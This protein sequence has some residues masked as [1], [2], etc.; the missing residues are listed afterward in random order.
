MQ[1][2]M[3]GDFL[4]AVKFTAEKLKDA[5]KNVY[6]V[7]HNDADGICS[8]LIL[9]IAL[10]RKGRE[11]ERYCIEKVHPRIIEKIHEGK[12]NDVI[13]YTDLGG[14]ALDTIAK[15]DGERN[16]IFLIDHHPA[17][18]VESRKVIELDS[19]L[20]GISGDLF[21]SASS[22]AYMVARGIDEKNKDLAYLAVIGS[23]GDYHDRYGGVL[24]IDRLSLEEAVRLGQA[25]IKIEKMRE[26]YYIVPLKNYAS[27]VAKAFTNLGVVGYLE[28]GYNIAIDC[29]LSG[30]IDDAI[31]KGLEYEKLKER[32]FKEMIEKLKNGEL[33]KERYV[34]WFHAKDE[35]YPMGVKAIGE[36]CQVTKD[37]SFFDDDKYIIGFQNFYDY[38]P[39]LGEIKL[40][41]VKVSGRTPIP[42]ERKIINGIMPGFD[43]LIPEAS[44]AVNGFPDATHKVAAATLIE[45]GKEEEFIRAFERIIETSQCG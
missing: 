35:F 37:M 19:E 39:D 26:R 22:L 9:T 27:D 15:I 24:G 29:T 28:K 20:L 14:L 25:K 8:A 4:K 30:N 21:I 6:I 7:H 41:A 44:K 13:I 11:V 38:I 36:F 32:K 1:E 23:V 16:Y 43:C 2:L 31:E 18:R 34:Q 45:R 10:M 5:T 3:N 42:L 17:V 12:E 40:N 33:K